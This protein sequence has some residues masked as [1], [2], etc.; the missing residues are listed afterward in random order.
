[1]LV[2]WGRYVWIDGWCEAHPSDDVATAGLAEEGLCE[3]RQGAS[4]TA[5]T[6]FDATQ[7]PWHLQEADKPHYLR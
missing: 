5:V 3:S 7:P 4:I 1:V 6:C 2:T